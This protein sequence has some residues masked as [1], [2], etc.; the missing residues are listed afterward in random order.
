M[1]RRVPL[2][3]I[4]Y[5]L[6]LIL[7]NVMHGTPD[8][9]ALDVSASVGTQTFCD[10]GN[11][12]CKR[13]SIAGSQEQRHVISP[14]LRG[15]ELRIGRKGTVHFKYGVKLLRVGVSLHKVGL[16]AR[17]EFTEVE[18]VTEIVG[19]PSGDE[20]FWKSR[21]LHKPGVPHSGMAL[22]FIPSLH[23]RNWRIEDHSSARRFWVKANE[24]ISHLPPEVMP[25]NVNARQFERRRK[26]M[27]VLRHI[28]RIITLGRRRRSAHAAQI[29]RD[30][31]ELFRQT[32]HDCVILEPVLREA[33]DQNDG[34]T[35]TPANVVKFDSIHRRGFGPEIFA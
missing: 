6:G 12:V 3:E 17:R 27:H 35:F 10:L 25:D 16:L 18:E 2:D 11:K 5:F 31:R 22:N 23:S 21:N 13:R 1:R 20:F 9:T 8:Q 15:V 4:G 14:T 28:R 7:D 33:M 32:R 29:N 19:L 30:Y 26:L 24:C 34:G